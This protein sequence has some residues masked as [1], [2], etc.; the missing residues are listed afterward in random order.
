M[1]GGFAESKESAGLCMIKCPNKR[2]QQYVQKKVG[3][4]CVKGFLDILER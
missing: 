3:L 4:Q 1:T 2:S